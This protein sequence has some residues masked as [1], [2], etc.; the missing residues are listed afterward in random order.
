MLVTGTCN[1]NLLICR[2]KHASGTRPQTSS[3]E[4][5]AGIF[6]Q[7]RAEVYARS[8]SATDA[9]LHKSL[10]TMIHMDSL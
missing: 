10:H 4:Y 1:S 3:W 9:P 2:T 6:T 7:E 8:E 5:M